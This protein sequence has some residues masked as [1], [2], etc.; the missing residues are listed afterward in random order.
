MSAQDKTPPLHQELKKGKQKQTNDRP[1]EPVV[2]VDRERRLNPL[3]TW[4]ENA[5]YR[6]SHTKEKEKNIKNKNKTKNP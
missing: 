1:R 2:Y 4:T 6:E 5:D 3:F